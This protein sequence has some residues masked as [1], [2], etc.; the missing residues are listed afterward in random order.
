AVMAQLV[1]GVAER[2]IA[3]E[4]VVG[5]AVPEVLAIEDGVDHRGG[6]AAGDPPV[7]EEG[8]GLVRGADVDRVG[9][10]DVIIAE[11]DRPDDALRADPVIVDD[12]HG[13]EVLA[14]CRHAAAREDPIRA[15]VERVQRAI[16]GAVVEVTGRACDLA[17]AAHLRIPEQRLAEF[18]G[19]RIVD[20][21][22]AGP[23]RNA[24][25]G[26]R[27]EIPVGDGDA[28]VHRHQPRSEQR[29][30]QGEDREGMLA[31]RQRFIAS[32]HETEPPRPKPDDSKQA[33][34]QLEKL[35]EGARPE[36]Y[37]EPPPRW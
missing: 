36:T 8:R 22:A 9:L 14:R 29:S 13:G 7:V 24:D 17:V 33:R 10:I 23:R 25:G 4:L 34:A 37:S 1:S 3:V 11:V 21:G 32:L 5:P 31:T 16:V 15:G 20:D 18:D 30:Y 2:I 27:G 6:I 28:D 26:K 12:V 35:A 19:G